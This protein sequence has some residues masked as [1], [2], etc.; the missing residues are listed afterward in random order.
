MF[1]SVQ[2][3]F[4]IIPRPYRDI[5]RNF[6]CWNRSLDSDSFITI[7]AFNE[8]EKEKKKRMML[9]VSY[10]SFWLSGRH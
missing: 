4:R 9:V 5:D 6:L 2:V 1:K 10:Q 3:A 7:N 8:S